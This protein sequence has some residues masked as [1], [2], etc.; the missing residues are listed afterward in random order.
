M[1]RLK[2]KT[3][4]SLIPE[5]PSADLVSFTK[6][7]GIKLVHIQISRVSPLNQALQNTM[8]SVL[9]MCLDTVNHPI[10]IHCLDGRRI[11][12]LVILMLRKIQGYSPL[13]AMEE[14]WRFQ[15][16]SKSP[17]PANEIEKN[18]RYI[19]HYLSNYITFYLCIHVSIY[20]SIKL[21]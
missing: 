6:V 21:S 11:V 17:I 1:S 7:A 2:L 18:T 15:T 5:S 10:H 16:V 9:N 20:Q 12:G 14:Y 13:P 19:Y 3:I 4:I 8:I